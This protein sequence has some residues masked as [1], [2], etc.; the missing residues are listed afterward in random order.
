MVPLLSLSQLLR[1]KATS[2]SVGVTPASL[3]W[4]V[5]K[6]RSW[7]GSSCSDLFLSYLWKM[8][9]IFVSSRTICMLTRSNLGELVEI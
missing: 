3:A 9:M 7:S 5:R 2:S 8:L 1:M 6:L 4:S